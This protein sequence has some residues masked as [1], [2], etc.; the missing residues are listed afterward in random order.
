MKSGQRAEM[1]FALC[2]KLVPM[3]SHI[4]F[5]LNLISTCICLLRVQ[6]PAWRSCWG[7]NTLRRSSWSGPGGS[8]Q[9]Q[10]A[11]VPPVSLPALPCS[12]FPSGAWWITGLSGASALAETHA[13]N[14]PAPPGSYRDHVCRVFKSL[15]QRPRAFWYFYIC[16]LSLGGGLGFRGCV[17]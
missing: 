6:K 8:A 4:P 3:Q 10:D 1:S 5:I 12:A 11:Q 13:Y 7:R 16:N 15:T 2:S 17:F 9:R 14:N